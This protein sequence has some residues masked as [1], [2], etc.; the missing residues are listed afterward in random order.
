MKLVQVTL[1]SETD[2]GFQRKR[3]HFMKYCELA[4]AVILNI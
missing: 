3:I 1:V 4:C 2:F